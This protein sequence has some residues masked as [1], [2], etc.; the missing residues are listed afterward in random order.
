MVVMASPGMLQNG[1]SRELFE[2]WAP[3]PK[4]GLIIAGY[5]V[6]VCGLPFAFFYNAG[7]ESLLMC[8]NGRRWRAGHPGQGGDEGARRGDDHGWRAHPAAPLGGV[9]L[10]LRP[11]R[12]QAGAVWVLAGRWV[13]SAGVGS[14]LTAAS[15][16]LAWPQNRDFIR[17]L[18]PPN[19]VLVHGEANEMR[20]FRDKL[21]QEYAETPEAT[22]A[23][24]S[25]E[26]LALVEFYFRGEKHAKVAIT[27]GQWGHG[28]CSPWRRSFLTRG[29]G[30]GGR[31]GRGHPRAGRAPRQRRDCQA[32][33]H[34]FGHGGRGPA[35]CGRA[36][37]WRRKR[38]G[39]ALL[40]FFPRG[41]DARAPFG[42]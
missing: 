11:R 34:L 25:P 35:R 39:L 4:N 24:H 28:V 10:L 8:V 19:V 22:V 1:L 12:L 30:S 17:A 13:L 27:A 29:D 16:R 20:R 18:N 5:C 9:H 23:V 15:S 31:P 38:G 42:R 33:L 7:W 6:E 21:L 32:R 2:L 26:N 40:F 37:A 41:A 3:D 36:G 14:L